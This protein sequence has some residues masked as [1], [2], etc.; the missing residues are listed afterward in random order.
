MSTGDLIDVVEA[1][2]RVD[3][4][5]TEWL[6]AVY[7]AALPHLDRGLGGSAF[8]YDASDIT[9]LRVRGFIGD[10][11]APESTIAAI[12]SA[13]PAR[14]EWVF[15][16]QACQTASEG[17]NGT[18]HPGLELFRSLGYEDVLFVN[19][20][21][22]SGKG[23]FLSAR[24]KKRSTLSRT[25]MKSWGWVAAHIAAGFR[26]RAQAAAANG[27]SSFLSRAEVILSPR[28]EIEHVAKALEED[29]R[30]MSRAVS[31]L[32][33]TALSIQRAR[34]KLRRTSEAEALS[35]WRALSGARW[36]MLDHFDRGGRRHLLACANE[37]KI[38]QP[39]TLSLRE[40][41][42]LAFAALGHQNTLIGYELGITASTV[43]V[44]LL[45]AIRKLSASSRQEAID[46][47]RRLSSATAA[48][49]EHPNAPAPNYLRR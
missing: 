32:K 18:D 34:G 31:V 47:F 40:R 33:S 7:D 5:E 22:P 28:G 2:Y 4:S 21:D 46:I 11:E 30:T 39:E 24:L 19:G 41:Q 9:N 1:S 42:V 45:R 49:G 14:T 6:A 36:T 25:T 27:P 20:V 13:S 26:L 8:F 15:R 3:L 29:R 23:V 10:G 16:T 17:P 44:L 38:P 48:T 12:E 43:G 37:H 35:G